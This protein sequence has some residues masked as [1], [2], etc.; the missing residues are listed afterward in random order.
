MRGWVTLKGVV[1]QVTEASVGGMLPD[2]WR[3]IW[4]L[5]H[6]QSYSSSS[7]GTR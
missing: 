5:P 1:G 7:H 2:M 4:A 3:I 6:D